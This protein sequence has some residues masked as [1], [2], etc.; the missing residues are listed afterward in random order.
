MQRIDLPEDGFLLKYSHTYLE[1]LETHGKTWFLLLK[2]LK[3]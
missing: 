1:N 3:L 2:M